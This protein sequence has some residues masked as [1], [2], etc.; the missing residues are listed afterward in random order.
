MSASFAPICM[1][2]LLGQISSDF[3][4]IFFQPMVSNKHISV[5]IFLVLNMCFVFRCHILLIIN[6]YYPT[7]KILRIKVPCISP[8]YMWYIYFT[9]G[10]LPVAVSRR[11]SGDYVEESWNITNQCSH[12]TPGKLHVRNW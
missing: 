5:N 12:F 3:N 6:H 11:R 4:L 9:S 7:P 8:V 2:A 10:V 1:P